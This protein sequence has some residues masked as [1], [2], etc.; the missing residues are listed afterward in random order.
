MKRIIVFSGLEVESARDLLD[1][2][3]QR[4]DFPDWYGANWNAL[5]DLLTGHIDTNVKLEFRNSS[6]LKERIGSA[7]FDVLKAQMADLKKFDPNFEY[8][9][10]D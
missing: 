1:L 6:I 7:N 4:L 2:F 9:F 5:W 8:E 10:S 3:S